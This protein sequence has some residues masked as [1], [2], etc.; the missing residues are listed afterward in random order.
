MEPV[1][2]DIITVDGEHPG[3]ASLDA[4]GPERLQKI[5]SACG[6]A[7]RRGAERMILDGR[8]TVNGTVADI[9]RSAAFGTDVI[10]VD[11]VKLMPGGEPVYIMLNKP[12]GYITTVKDERGRKTV[13][14]LVSVSGA[15]VYPAGRLDKDSEGLLLLTNDGGFAKIVTHPSGNK[16]KTY[17]VNVRGNISGAVSLLRSPMIIDSHPVQANSAVVSKRSGSGGVLRIS[18]HEGRN[19]QIRKMCAKCGLEVEKLKR[20]A[21]GPLELGSLKPGEWRYLTGDEVRELISG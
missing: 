4:R 7:S 21:V 5:L 15:A 17:E 20:V 6:V 16:T 12:R 14:E 19:R 8:V 2:P 11:G 1:D 10:E 9:G 18:I 3:S 13:M